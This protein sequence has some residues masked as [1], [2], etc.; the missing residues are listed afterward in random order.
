MQPERRRTANSPAPKVV[1]IDREKALVWKGPEYPI[2]T[3]GIYTAAASKLQGPEWVR[4]FHRWSL[5]IEFTLMGDAGTVSAFFNFGSAPEGPHIGRQSRYYKA[6]VL[7]NGGHP[8]KGEKMA[9][10]VF[11]E[12]M[13]FELEVADCNRDDEGKPKPNAE[14]YSRVTRIVSVTRP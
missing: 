1:P 3:P 5:R 11:L 7:A 4:S 13:I 8:M 2:L 9:P 14:V 6:W 10:G 12:N